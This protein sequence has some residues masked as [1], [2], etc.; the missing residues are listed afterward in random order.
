MGRKKVVGACR[1]CCAHGPL[2][3]SHIVSKAAYRRAAQGPDGEIPE[4][5]LVEVTRDGARRTTKQMKEYLLCRACEDRFGKW[6]RYAYPVLAQRDSDFPWLAASRTVVGRAADSSAMDVDALARF[7][8]S[9][10]WRLGVY[11]AART[12]QEKPD[13]EAT[14]RYLLGQTAFPEQAVLAVTLLDPSDSTLARV[15]R[16]FTN[17]WL[18]G[19]NG[20]QLYQV[21]ILGVDARLLMGAGIPRECYSVCFARTRLVTVRP[22]DEFAGQHAEFIAG[23]A[24]ADG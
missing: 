6:E 17:I 9:I 10:V 12:R 23:R 1:L 16:L 15:D 18:G 24:R 3:K 20:Y 22:S 7:L 4:R 13:E 21:V 14:R 19:G 8:L 2:E 11:K 5:G